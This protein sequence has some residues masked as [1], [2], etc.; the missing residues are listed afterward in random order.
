MAEAIAVAGLRNHLAKSLMT[1]L[2][3]T[4]C[5]WPPQPSSYDTPQR[6][7]KMFNIIGAESTCQALYYIHAENVYFFARTI[8]MGASAPTAPMVPPPLR[9]WK[10]LR[11]RALRALG[12]RAI[13]RR[14]S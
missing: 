14:V 1:P 4:R 7:R 8:F 3:G 12:R 11:T 5:S 9:P 13:P 10:G 6:R 2:G